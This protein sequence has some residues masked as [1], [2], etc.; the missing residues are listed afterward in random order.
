MPCRPTDRHNPD[1][2]NQT[3]PTVVEVNVTFSTRLPRPPFQVIA[4]L[5]LSIML[6][7]ACQPLRT[8]WKDI[9]PVPTAAPY[10]GQ[11]EKLLKERMASRVSERNL[12]VLGSRLEQLPLDVTFTQHVAWRD[13]NANDMR[14]VT[15]RVPEPDAPVMMAEFAR[16]GRTLFVIGTVAS[17]RIVVL[18][19]PR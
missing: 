18:T 8:S 5:L 17:G 6:A 2:P 15:D 12:K 19:A 10:E 13:A 9:R 16:A 14:Q 4:V 7:T 11:A 1:V 3:T